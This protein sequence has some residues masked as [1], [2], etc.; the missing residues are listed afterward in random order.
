MV[1]FDVDGAVEYGTALPLCRQTAAVHSIL[2]PPM[3][4]TVVA[5]FRRRCHF[6]SFGRATD[7]IRNYVCLLLIGVCRCDT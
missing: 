7:R 3:M 6:L 5:S 1:S 4:T 2:I